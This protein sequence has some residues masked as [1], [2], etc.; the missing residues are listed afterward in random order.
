MRK[1]ELKYL[2]FHNI[3]LTLQNIGGTINCYIC[4][5]LKQLLLFLTGLLCW[6]QAEAQAS[7]LDKPDLLE[8]VDICLQHTYNFSFQEA[9]SIQSDIST[10][11]PGHPAPLFLEALIIYWENFPLAPSKSASDQ[12]VELMD[13]T[14]E[15]AREYI[16]KEQTYIDGVFFDLFGR[17]FKAMFWADNEKIGKVI[18][19]LGTMYRHVK[20]GFELQ[21][22]FVEFYF[23]TGLYNY[24]IEAYPTAHPG[25]KPLVSFMHK[26]DR[27]LGLEQLKY[28]TEHTIFL[29]VESLLFMSLIQLNYENDINTAAFYA[30]RLLEEY[31]RNILFQGH[32][33]N[34]LLH[35]HKY[36]RVRALFTMILG[37]GDDYSKMIY[38]LADAF[39]S[40]DEPGQENISASGYLKTIEMAETIGPFADIYQAMGYMGLSRLYQNRGLESDAE[41]YARKASHYTSY[42][43]ILQ[44]K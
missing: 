4:W 32:M 36:D 14:I 34:I 8:Q 23:S 43:F 28:A 1:K 21:E 6:V 35:Q 19:D 18:P 11:M 13:Q 20:E 5:M 22:Q 40:E 33:I 37:Q 24:Y 12:F 10:S 41:S 26:G 2:L 42:S 25:Y 7:L 39:M 9:R 16:K 44:E 17:A 38:T 27:E 29:K 3:S 31:P 15:L 30:E